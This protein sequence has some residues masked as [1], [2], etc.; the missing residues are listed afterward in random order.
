MTTPLLKQRPADYIGGRFVP[1]VGDALISYDP[2]NPDNVVWRCAP[3]PAHV[4]EAVGAARNAF[5]AW[6]ARSM[7]DRA[8]FLKKLAAITAQNADLIAELI[9]D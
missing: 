6:A 8:A 9:T 3:N 7:D 2:S 4:N 5:G 1:I